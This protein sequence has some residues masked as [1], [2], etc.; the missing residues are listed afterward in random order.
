MAGEL[1]TVLRHA[2]DV[3]GE[4]FGAGGD[5]IVFVDNATTGIN[6]VLESYP[7]QYGDHL[8]ILGQAYP[9]VMNAARRV[10]ERHGL[11]L[12]TIDFEL[13][14]SAPATLIDEIDAVISNGA[15]LLL[16]DHISSQYSVILP[17]NEIVQA[18]HRR[19]VHILVDGAHAP[20]M[21]DLDLTKIDADWYVGNAH[22]WL[23]APKGCGFIWTNPK[24]GIV[25]RPLVASVF[26]GEGYHK[27]FDWQGTRDP[28]PWLASGAGV[29]FMRQL[30]DTQ[31][32]RYM[33]DLVCEGSAWL[34]AEVGGQA[35]APDSM[36]GAM[37]TTCLPRAFGS[38]SDEARCLHDY[39]W[40]E[41]RVEVPVMAHSNHLFLRLS[42]QVYN[43]ITDYEALARALR[44]YRQRN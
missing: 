3:L 4:Y 20:G 21:L 36:L 18:C 13:P 38:S 41:H 8:A 35:I 23:Y 31:A 39:L 27:E 9:G 1:S 26:W 25:P 6:A 12:D 10:S 16:M 40:S 11:R 37:A 28:T 5:D 32:R 24:T 14:F 42:A 44:A 19:G 15:R 43:D 29:E 2:A 7:W 22:K 33:H 30:D 17:V 34:R